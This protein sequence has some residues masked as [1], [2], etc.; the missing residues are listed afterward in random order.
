MWIEKKK[1][2]LKKINCYTKSGEYSEVIC[3]TLQQKLDQTVSKII[4]LSM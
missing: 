2:F 4:F 3:C 1:I